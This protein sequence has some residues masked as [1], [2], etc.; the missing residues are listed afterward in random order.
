MNKSVENHEVIQVEPEKLYDISR[1]CNICNKLAE[2]AQIKFSFPYNDKIVLQ[3]NSDNALIDNCMQSIQE[4]EDLIIQNAKISPHYQRTTGLT[5][6]QL[7]MHIDEQALVIA[8]L[9]ISKDTA[10]VIAKENHRKLIRK[11]SL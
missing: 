4:S 1:F 11:Q 9:K 5:N 7:G 6:N 3:A 8:R 10:D 2:A